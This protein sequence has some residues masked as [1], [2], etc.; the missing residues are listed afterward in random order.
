MI[1]AELFQ[2]LARI[3]SFPSVLVEPCLRQ[4]DSLVRESIVDSIPIIKGDLAGPN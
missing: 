2:L 3:D 4:S 1:A